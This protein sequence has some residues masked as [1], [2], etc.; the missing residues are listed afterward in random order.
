MAFNFSSVS[1]TSWCYFKVY[2]SSNY[3]CLSASSAS[4]ISCILSCSSYSFCFCAKIS[5]FFYYSSNYSY[6]YLILS[7]LISSSSIWLTCSTFFFFFFFFFL[8][9]VSYLSNP[10]ASSELG[11]IDTWNEGSLLSI[12][13]RTR[14]YCGIYWT[15]SFWSKSYWF[16]TMD[17]G[18]LKP[19][20]GA[21]WLIGMSSRRSSSKSSSF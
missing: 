1:C 7:S 20:C 9:A 17:C 5:I 11:S 19:S 21:A 15:Y 10:S 14:I 4:Y 8:P 13:D 12:S 16:W 6:S 3:F 18:S 2:S